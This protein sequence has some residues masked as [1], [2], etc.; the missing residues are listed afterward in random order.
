MNHLF[1]AK[2]K[3]LL[4]G[5]TSCFKP[6]RELKHLKKSEMEIVKV[7]EGSRD[8]NAEAKEIAEICIGSD[9]GTALDESSDLE[10]K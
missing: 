6:C 3:R 2:N 10:D 8:Q 9:A 7:I 1:I 4:V 5:S